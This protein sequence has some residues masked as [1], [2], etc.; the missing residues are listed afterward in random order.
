MPVD[1]NLRRR[2]VPV[3]IRLCAR[4]RVTSTSQ[5][6]SADQQG[7]RAVATEGDHGTKEEHDDVAKERAQGQKGQVPFT[8]C[9][10]F[11]LHL[12]SAR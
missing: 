12:F 11:A 1:G 7:R 10:S 9:S 8:I 6:T 2:S 4:T 5:L 3:D